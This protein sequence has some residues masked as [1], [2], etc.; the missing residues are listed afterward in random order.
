MNYKTSPLKAI[1]SHCIDCCGGS[2]NEVKLSQCDPCNLK[3]YKFGTNPYRKRRV[4]SDEQRKAAA[5]RLSAAR[6]KKK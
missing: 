2:A 3:P 5:V 4:M 6:E 1:K